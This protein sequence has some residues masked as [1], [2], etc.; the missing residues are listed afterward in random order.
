MPRGVSPLGS[1]VY[2]IMYC[3]PAGGATGRPPCASKP[4]LELRLPLQRLRWP[5]ESLSSVLLASELVG[6]PMLFL[7]LPATV[8]RRFALG[9]RHR[10]GFPPDDVTS[11]VG[12]RD[13]VVLVRTSSLVL[14]SQEDF[15]A[16]HSHRQAR[17]HAEQRSGPIQIHRA[18]SIA[19]RPWS[20]GG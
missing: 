2:H 18:G 5:S 3:P 14:G 8:K 16:A 6:A 19:S 7:A 13:Q 1:S 12:A 17:A 15:V 20:V 11:V 4:H 9:T 10:D